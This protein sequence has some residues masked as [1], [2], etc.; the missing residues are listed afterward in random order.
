MAILEIFYGHMPS[1]GGLLRVKFLYQ[2]NPKALTM[3]NG[4]GIS[5]VDFLTTPCVARADYMDSREVLSVQNDLLKVIL[6]QGAPFEI[7]RGYER[8]LPLVQCYDRL[9]SACN[10][11]DA[12]KT[13]ESVVKF[14][15]DEL[16]LKKDHYQRDYIFQKDHLS[17]QLDQQGNTAL[18]ISIKNKYYL[19]IFRLLELNEDTNIPNKENETALDLA[20]KLVDS[21]PFILLIIQYREA[22]E[23]T[24]AY[25]IVCLNLKRLVAAN[26]GFASTE[27]KEKKEDQ[28]ITDDDTLEIQRRNYNSEL[29][30]AQSL[31]VKIF[32]LLPKIKDIV[33]HLN[34]FPSDM[35]QGFLNEFSFIMRLDDHEEP[36][37]TSALS[38]ALIFT[39][40]F[41]VAEAPASS[42]DR[43][44]PKEQ[45]RQQGHP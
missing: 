13:Y 4:N 40:I 18:H 8:E 29:Q 38:A 22:W 33:K 45:Q 42:G 17:A 27:K 32:T 10:S 31:R 30:K 26:P 39:Q 14:F 23:L 43:I 25:K 35:Q 1:D 41:G 34:K 19:M 24:Q 36:Q 37:P 6:S 16:K 20:K 5:P 15:D 28:N 2:A 11:P 9:L 12:F 7:L 3:K 44:K 21:D